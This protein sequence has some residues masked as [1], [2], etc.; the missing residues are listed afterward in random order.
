MQYFVCMYVYHARVGSVCARRNDTGQ[1]AWDPV[2]G[3]QVRKCP[4]WVCGWMGVYDKMIGG[5]G[6]FNPFCLL[7]RL[8]CQGQHQRGGALPASCAKRQGN[9]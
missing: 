1:R 7:I 8:Q 3:M 2:R 6:R 4:F 9:V 5:P